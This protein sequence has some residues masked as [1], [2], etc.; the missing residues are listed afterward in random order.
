MGEKLDI[1]K[2]ERRYELATR[3]LELD[4]TMTSKNK[5]L[6]KNFLYDCALGKTIKNKAKKKIGVG[7]RLRYLECLVDISRWFNKSLDS[8]R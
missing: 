6:I 3:N 4:A 5:E 7:R 8:R 1:H 2:R